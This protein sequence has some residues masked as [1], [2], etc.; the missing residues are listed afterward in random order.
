MITVFPCSYMTLS[1]PEYST[2]AWVLNI[3]IIGVILLSTAT[4]CAETVPSV[5]KGDAY[6]VLE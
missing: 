4:F 3:F 6:H 2:F 5:E 1:H